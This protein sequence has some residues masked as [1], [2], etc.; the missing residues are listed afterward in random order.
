MNHWTIFIVLIPSVKYSDKEGDK[1]IFLFLF[2]P[3]YI[4]IENA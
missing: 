3:Y 4:K 1:I 2:F